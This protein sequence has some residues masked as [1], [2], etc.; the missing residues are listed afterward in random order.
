MASN[1]PA[2]GATVV[3]MTEE[4]SRSEVVA[5]MKSAFIDDPVMHE[6]W[7]DERFFE[8]CV[9][10]FFEAVVDHNR[11]GIH[12]LKTPEGEVAGVAV[13]EHAKPAFLSEELAI[14]W[15]E[16][17]RAGLIH[18]CRTIWAFFAVV[19]PVLSGFQ[20]KYRQKGMA[21]L[22]FLAV[23]SKHHGKGF[24]TRLL[25]ETL[26][27]E[28]DKTGRKTFVESSNPRNL[29]LYQRQGFVLQEEAPVRKAKMFALVR[30]I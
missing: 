14:F 27:L 6:V 17:K 19:I 4:D 8:G 22:K 29:T 9:G 12:L 21:Y 23:S 30:D 7:T 1:A 26:G 24:G 11:D 13:Y 16:Y 18:V 3:K 20:K 2:K 25:S 5:V 10:G 15:S 28:A